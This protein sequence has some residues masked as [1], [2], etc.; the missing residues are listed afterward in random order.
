M[1]LVLLMMRLVRLGGSKCHVQCIGHCAVG[2]YCDAAIPLLGYLAE[3]GDSHSVCGL[4][5]L[6]GGSCELM[7]SWAV[8]SVA[9]RGI[10]Q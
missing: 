6:G 7:R 5:V 2:G 8:K 3:L 1:R 9:G 4:V 10:E